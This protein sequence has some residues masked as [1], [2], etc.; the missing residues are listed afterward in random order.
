M[1][2][3]QEFVPEKYLEEVPTSTPITDPQSQFV[4]T[5]EIANAIIIICAVIA[6]ILTLILII[7][8]FLPSTAKY[9]GHLVGQFKKGQKE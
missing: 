1:N 3:D 6:I 5:P 9:R 4:I 8:Y 7:K 2:L